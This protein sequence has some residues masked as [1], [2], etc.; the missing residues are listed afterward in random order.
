MDFMDN[1]FGHFYIKK[2]KSL[3]PAEIRDSVRQNLAVKRHYVA[4]NRQKKLVIL[5]HLCQLAGGRATIKVPEN[6]G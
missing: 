1:L 3:K 5:S 4:D 2:G 6:G